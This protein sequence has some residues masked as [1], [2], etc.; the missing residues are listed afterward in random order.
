[1]KAIQCS[2]REVKNPPPLSAEHAFQTPLVGHT[3]NT[4]YS[5]TKQYHGKRKSHEM[6]VRTNVSPPATHTYKMWGSH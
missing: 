6:T 1:M 4:E 3:I 5:V 2:M